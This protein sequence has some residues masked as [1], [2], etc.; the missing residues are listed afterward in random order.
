[1]SAETGGCSLLR[2][3][4]FSAGHS[5]RESFRCGGSMSLPVCPDVRHTGA[6]PDQ[7]RRSRDE[8]IENH[9]GLARSLARRFLD[10]GETL[11]DLVQVAMIGLVKAADRFDET[12]DIQ[13]STYATVT[14]TG[15]LK[16]HFRD[17]RWGLHVTR[18]S[19]ELYLLVRQATEWA[20]E[21]VRR[22]PTIAEIASRAGVSE[23]EVLEAQ[24][25][26]GAFY[27]DSID[28]PSKSE[29]GNEPM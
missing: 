9:L 10:R 25:L 24:E 20:R 17:A 7:R 29:D 28:L 14:I 26:A 13:F 12:R 23:E 2:R 6:Q 4:A 21:D 27:I 15:E 19:Q 3:V 18:R 11:D 22:S 1:M 8:L 16:R 5:T